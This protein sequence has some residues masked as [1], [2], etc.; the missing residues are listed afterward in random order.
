MKKRSSYILF[1]CT[2]LFAVFTVGF[3]LGRNSAAPIIT[4][5]PV[6]PSQ[7]T[8][9]TIAAKPAAVVLEKPA[10]ATN[11]EVTS[12]AIETQ[13]L[14]NINTASLS[15][16]TALPGVGEIIALRIIDY[17]QTNGPF[18]QISDLLNVEGIG[19]KRLEALLPLITV[20][21]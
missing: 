12:A 10:D 9:E 4:V 17:R 11:P 20:G 7:P 18:Q 8:T 14:L 16:L 13:G 21:G 1:A 19:E 6:P 5:S 15:E 2:A 3:F